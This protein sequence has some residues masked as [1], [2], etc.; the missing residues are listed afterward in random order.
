VGP[1]VPSTGGITGSN[2]KNIFTI[3]F[4]QQYISERVDVGYTALDLI[5]FMINDQWQ[6]A[7]FPDTSPAHHHQGQS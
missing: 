7:S 4:K 5:R 1:G 3:V 6:V 2:L